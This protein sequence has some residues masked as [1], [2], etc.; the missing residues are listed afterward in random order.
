M[1]LPEASCAPNATPAPLRQC[2]QSNA[3]LHLLSP[4]YVP[5]QRDLHESAETINRFLIPTFLAAKRR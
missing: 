2:L 4:V 5:S 3:G 1:N